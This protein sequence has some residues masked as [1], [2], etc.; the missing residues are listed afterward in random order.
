LKEEYHKWHT[1]HLNRE[2]EMLV[3]G[4]GGMP[5]VIFPTAQERYYT[6]KDCGLISS[7]QNLIEEGKINIYCPD[8]IDSES[9]FNYSIQPGERVRTH[10]GYENAMLYDVIDYAIYESGKDKVTVGGCGFGG[11]HAINFAFK[12]P[13]KVANVISIGAF[14]DIKRFIFGYYD[15]NCYFNNPPDYMPNLE[16]PWYLNKIKKMKIILGTGEWDQN[17][18]ENKRLSGILS[19]KEISHLLDI[20][21]NAGGDWGWWREMFPGY[22]NRII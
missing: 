20:K 6:Y 10:I 5:I 21:Q 16:D 2:F 18:E 19:K 15:E 4:H 22:I 1:L 17:L 3:F 8:G 11:Y 14:F 12:H 13:D 7:V 9:W